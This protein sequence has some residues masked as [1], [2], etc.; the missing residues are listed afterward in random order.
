[1]IDADGINA[2]EGCPEEIR[3]DPGDNS[4]RVITPHP[5]EMATLMGI[6]ADDIQHGRINVA[7]DAAGKT[8]VCVVLKGHRT[9]I[10][11]PRGHV[12]INPTGNPGMAKGGSGDVLA[13]IMGAAIARRFDGVSGVKSVADP[14][15]HKINMLK[16]KQKYGAKDREAAKL[17]AEKMA[18]KA[19]EVLTLLATLN[20]GRAVYLH[21]LAGDIAR[22]LY[23]ESS[24]IAT[25]IIACIAEAMATCRGE[26]AGGFAYLQ[27]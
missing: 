7:R 22:E 6:F 19:D 21:G 9:V 15:G 4:F 3:R 8:G 17:L 23:G 5:G 16:Q 20:A 1:V 18:V 25:D 26:A 11:S 13:G 12:W 27:R 24:M 2:F 10:A 14:E